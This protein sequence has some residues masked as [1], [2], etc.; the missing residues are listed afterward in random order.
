M[1]PSFAVRGPIARSGRFFEHP[2]D[3]V[4]ALAA[5]GTA[6]EVAINLAHPRPL[7]GLLKSRQ[8]LMI[9]KDVA[10]AD[11]HALLLCL[12]G[13]SLTGLYWSMASAA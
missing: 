9:S 7:N 3:G 5:L 1:R 13:E 6:A 8:E 4:G 2:L 12:S 11:D 10:R